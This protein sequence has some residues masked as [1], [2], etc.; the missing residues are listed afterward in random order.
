MSA[1]ISG[2]EVEWQSVSCMSQNSVLVVNFCRILYSR[3]TIA[4]M[5]VWRESEWNL[6][7]KVCGAGSVYHHMKKWV[8]FC[9]HGD[10]LFFNV[11]YR[12]LWK[13]PLRHLHSLTAT[14]CV[15]VVSSQIFCITL[16]DTYLSDWTLLFLLKWYVVSQSEPQTPT[17]MCQIGWTVKIVCIS[18]WKSSCHDSTW[19]WQDS[20]SPIPADCQDCMCPY[21]QV[22]IHL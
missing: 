4:N 6:A 5:Y 18:S 22:K 3:D 13:L 1:H 21:K 19:Y 7:T 8:L 15:W 16:R 20:W 9:F 17:A 11:V 10:S 14:K 12:P 2:C